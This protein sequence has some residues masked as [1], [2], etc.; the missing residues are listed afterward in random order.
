MNAKLII[1]ITSLLVVIFA[2]IAFF[3]FEKKKN[4]VKVRFWDVIV[5]IV[6]EFLFKYVLVNILINAITYIP[7]FERVVTN[8]LGYLIIYFLLTAL[9]LIC[10]LYL[11]YRFYFGGNMNSSS[12]VGITIGM[13]VA[14]I[15]NTTLM[16]AISNIVYLFQASNG[17]FLTNLLAQ[18]SESQA[19]EV[20]AR[21]ESFGLNYYLYVGI[22]TVAMLASSYLTSSLFCKSTKDECIK[23]YFIVFAA[24]IIYS[25]I[26]Y[27]NDPTVMTF[28]NP[29]LLVFAGMQFIFA[30]INN[31]TLA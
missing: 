12:V 30:E 14:T 19:L 9:S 10:G 2:P 26:Y 6:V 15:L 11:V 25:V 13:C 18:V 20:V 21:Y 8:I 3:I 22:I 24:I 4:K 28:A 16:A 1:S 17:T 29:L 5:G 31:R 23:N 27:F 7:L